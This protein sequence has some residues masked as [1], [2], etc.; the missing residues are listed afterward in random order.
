MRCIKCDHAVL[1]FPNSKWNKSVDYLFFRNNIKI[2]PNLKKELTTSTGYCAF[3]CQCT[4]I[5]VK[6]EIDLEH[7][8]QK[9]WVCGGHYI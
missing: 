6:D 4:W 3:C 5:S 1:R 8:S 7:Q 2:E 9:K